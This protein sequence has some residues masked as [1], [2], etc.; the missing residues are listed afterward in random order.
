MRLALLGFHARAFRDRLAVDTTGA[1]SG[2]F[3][4]ARRAQLENL[5]PSAR[6]GGN[7]YSSSTNVR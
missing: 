6:D 7:G 2:T 3:V 5:H 1:S 4:V